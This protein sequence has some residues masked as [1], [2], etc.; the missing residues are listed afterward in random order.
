[1]TMKKIKSKIRTLLNSN[2]SKCVSCCHYYEEFTVKSDFTI[3]GYQNIESMTAYC[4]CS[5]H[6]VSIPYTISTT[7]IKNPSVLF[8]AQFETLKDIN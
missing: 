8:C 7:G 2:S 4:Y 1:M 5:L 6:A 3:L